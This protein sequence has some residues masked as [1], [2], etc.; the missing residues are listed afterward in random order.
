MTEFELIRLAFDET[1]TTP[2][3]AAWLA[4]ERLSIAITKANSLFLIGVDAGG[5]IAVSDRVYG[6]CMG[7]AAIGSDTLL[8]ATRYQI[9]RLQNA[10]PHGQTSDAGHDRVYLPQTAWTT[11]TLLVRDLAVMRDESIV[12]VN[13][14]FSCLSTPSPRLSFEPV[15]LPPFI[16]SLAPEERCHLSGLALDDDRPA[17]VTSASTSDSPGG[18]RERQRGGGVAVSVAT[19]EVIATGLSMPNSPVLHD[20]TLWLCNGGSGELVTIDLD[21]GSMTTVAALPGFS[22]GLALYGEHAITAVSGPQRNG[23][24]AGLPLAERLPD[25]AQSR[26][27]IFVVRLSTGEIEHSVT[28]AG[29]SSDIQALAVLPGVRTAAAVAFAGD[30]VQEL[31]TVPD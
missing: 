18:W 30:D 4:A 7:L 6:M 31:V 23:N 21:D 24:F 12:F 1:R 16:S 28:F 27:G 14:L 26:C 20:G 17:V 15:W 25:E 29:G 22:R 8:L 5:C 3:L 13:G 11:G 10:L 2:D 9:W 19:G